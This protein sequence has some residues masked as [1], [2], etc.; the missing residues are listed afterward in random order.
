MARS[1][2]TSVENNF[3]SALVTEASGL[4]FPENACTE[5]YD[6]VFNFNG[7]VERRPGFDFETDYTTKNIDRTDSV[8]VTYLWKNVAGDGDVTLLV[9]Q[10]GATLYFYELSASGAV[11]AG[12][13]ATTINLDSYKASGA[14]TTAQL[15]CQFTAGNGLLFV[16]H[17]YL[18]PLRVSFNTSTDTATPTAIVLK[19][20]DL[21]GDTADTEAVDSRPTATLAALDVNHK[22]NL[23]NQGWST[24]NLTTWDGAFTTM[25]SNCD[26]MWAFKNSSDA[27]DTATVANVYRG[28]SP[29][30]RG[31][32][33]LDLCNQDRDTASGLS[34]AT[35]ATTSYQRPSSCAF[36][37]GRV[38]YSGINYVGYNSKIYFSQIVEREEQYGFCYQQNDLTSEDAFDALP[39]D[40]GVI[41]ILEAGT[42][43]KLVPAAGG[44]LVFA[45]NGVWFISGSTG[46]G[47]TATDFTVN[48]VSSIAALSAASFVDVG[49]TP[50]WWNGEGI[51]TVTGGQG[52]S[53]TV[54]SLTH[55][56]IKSEY[57][58]ISLENKTLTRGFFNPTT[59]VIQWLYHSHTGL[60]SSTPTQEYEYDRILNYNT[61]T[62]AFYIWRI[63]ESTVKMHSLFVLNAQS[64]QTAINT[65]IDAATNT[66]IDAST[67][68]VVVFASATTTQAPAFKYVVSYLDGAT[69]KFTFADANNE[70]YVDWFKYDTVG[71]NYTS[72]FVTGYKI[73]GE[74]LRKFSPLWVKVF[75]KTEETVAYYFQS[76]WDYANTG[77]TGRWSSRSYVS[78]TDTNYDYSMRR[79][80]IRG[81]GVVLQF[82]VSSVD[83]E[84]FHISGWSAFETGNSVP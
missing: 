42:V 81:H 75:A 48:Q 36:F 30:P 43:I 19:I 46:L 66:V 13:L 49:G 32:Y 68:T 20:R 84:P 26:V 67:N 52:G 54:Q 34:G 33:I 82:K 22:Y 55:T 11:S 41:N 63:S 25:P 74:G 15:E 38:F 72:Y 83:G 24:A 2:A 28:N 3:R 56:T 12:A 37:A 7:S 62:N 44:L 71:E 51:Y 1:A 57:D 70:T 18:D 40:G 4:N 64:G 77:D 14:P 79:L 16:A 61:Q 78:H 73:H 5:T 6:C 17:P 53:P 59:S 45:Q 31:H 80:K 27:F 21:Q 29:A 58:L 10:V 9:L 50:T 35:A 60:A 69:Y 8:V 65:V 76:I 39:S 47:F 23:Y